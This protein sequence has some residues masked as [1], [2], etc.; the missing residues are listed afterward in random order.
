M[1][2]VWFLTVLFLLAIPGSAK[3]VNP[4]DFTV[5]ATVTEV[6][7]QQ[8]AETVNTTH[9]VLPSYCNDPK[10]TYQE[11]YCQTAAAGGD[12]A[13]IKQGTN[14]F[15]TVE[16]GDKIYKLQGPRLELG[17]YKV[18]FIKASKRDSGG[19]SFLLKDKKDKPISVLYRIAGERLK[20]HDAKS[21][22]K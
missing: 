16:I 7:S 11:Y 14:F 12:T 1:K 6:S 20:T 9:P 17:D 18:Q 2:T 5:S 10:G 22:T 13:S 15:M 21:D 4:A 8:F 3:K 19:I